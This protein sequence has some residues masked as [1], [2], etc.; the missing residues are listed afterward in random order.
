MGNKSGPTRLGCAV[1]L[2]CLQYEGRFPQPP[3]D[4]PA[5]GVEY[6]AR[7]V[8]VA[9][10]AWAH[11]DWHGRSLESHRAQMRAQLG[12]RAGT[13]DDGAALIAWL[14]AHGLAT[15]QRGEHLMDAV[16]GW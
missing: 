14:G 15:T 10:H 7:Q 9:P 1:L 8:D 6:V 2:K 12:C 5:P 13:I 16:Y 11:D 4:I 3:H